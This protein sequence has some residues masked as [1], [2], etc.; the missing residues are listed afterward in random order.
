MVSAA[1]RPAFPRGASR[2]LRRRPETLP[3][4]PPPVPPL[5]LTYDPRPLPRPP[6]GCPPTPPRRFLRPLTLGRRPGL[7]NSFV[8][9]SRLSLVSVPPPPVPRSPPEITWG[10]VGSLEPPAPGCASA[11]LPRFRASEGRVWAAWPRVRQGFVT[12]GGA[13]PRRPPS[14]VPVPPSVPREGAA[15]SAEP[16]CPALGTGRRRGEHRAPR[17]RGAASCAVPGLP[18]P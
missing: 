18:T 5:A 1:V 15:L 7:G 9:G 17:P 10:G 4:K 3:S 13:T 2:G 12:T 14:R 6:A 16:G 8:S 11:R